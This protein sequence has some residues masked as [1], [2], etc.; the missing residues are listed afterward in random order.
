MHIVKRWIRQLLWRPFELCCRRYPLLPFRATVTEPVEGVTCIRIDNHITR[1]LSRL[2]GGYDYA[3]SYLVDGALLVDTGFPWARRAL[4]RTL[5]DLGADRTL[6]FVVNTHYHEDHTGNNDLLAEITGADILAH[7]FA[8]PEIQFP[9][10]LPWYRS[11]LFGP[12]RTVEV[13][14]IGSHVVTEHRRFEVH[15]LPGHYPGHICLFEPEKRWL[16]SGDL[17]VAADLDSQLADADGPAWIDSLGKAIALR[18]RYLFDAHGTILAGEASVLELL[19]R[20][21][22]FL[23]ELRRR[24]L[25]EARRPR[26]IREI[27]RRVFDQRYLV[28][29]VSFSDGWLSLITGSDFSRAN[30]IRSF[31][32]A[33]GAG[34]AAQSAL[35][36]KG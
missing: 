24:I 17:Y 11:F 6:R 14:P 9:P 25:E 29:H 27:T 4:K 36:G 31:L 18:P 13:L 15:H 26:S 34:D 20:K 23:C 10:E 19:A 5:L 33:E 35:H 21:R 2:G 1:L 22:D 30:L 32:R 8:V 28:N 3:V 12:T 7:P 16:F